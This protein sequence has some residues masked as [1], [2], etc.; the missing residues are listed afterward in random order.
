[1]E[2]DPIDNQAASSDENDDA[3][4]MQA[5]GQEV[6]AYLDERLDVLDTKL[7]QQAEILVAIKEL[8]S[9][10]TTAI[11]AMTTAFTAPRML[12]NDENG[13]PIGV[14]TMRSLS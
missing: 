6:R 11:T 14:R 12:V 9:A 3:E 7:D 10:M 13:R 1:M 4:L 8:Q 5:L 2:T